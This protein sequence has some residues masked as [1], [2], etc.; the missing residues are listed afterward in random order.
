MV[1]AQ[2]ALHTIITWMKKS[3]KGR[4]EWEVVVPKET[5]LRAMKLKTLVKMSFA[6]KTILF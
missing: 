6:F 1:E 4:Q 3:R 2:N 5:S